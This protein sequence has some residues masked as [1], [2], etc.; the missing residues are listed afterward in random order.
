M[1]SSL[2]QDYHLSSVTYKIQRLFEL[3]SGL[4][5]YSEV[6]QLLDKLQAS[7]LQTIL[8]SPDIPELRQMLCQYLLTRHFGPFQ[9]MSLPEPLKALI[10]PFLREFV[11]PLI[12]ELEDLLRQGK[13]SFYLFA[14]NMLLREIHFLETVMVDFEIRT[15]PQEARR[16][17]L[18]AHAGI[19]LA[20][21]RIPSGPYVGVNP[22]FWQLLNDYGWIQ[23]WQTDSQPQ[24]QPVISRLS[25]K[26]EIAGYKLTESGKL[27]YVALEP[28]DMLSDGFKEALHHHVGQRLKQASPQLNSELERDLRELSQV[29]MQLAVRKHPAVEKITA[30]LIEVVCHYLPPDSPALRALVLFTLVQEQVLGTQNLKYRLNDSTRGMALALARLLAKYPAWR[31]DLPWVMAALLDGVL[32]IYESFN[33]ADNALRSFLEAFAQEKE[34]L[35]HLTWEKHAPQAQ[36]LLAAI[37]T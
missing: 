7:Q 10:A 37:Q 13:L 17:F 15:T 14:R 27:L 5:L 18:F 6:G 20:L 11:P 4:S 12:A 21:L 26:Q 22:L 31:S 9:S 24:Q 28:L 2:Q 34:Q 35:M 16:P 33:L 32:E 19:Y 8:L 36:A 25:P 30:Q 1:S 23:R 3:R 29:V